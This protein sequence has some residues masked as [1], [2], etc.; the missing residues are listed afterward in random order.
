MGVARNELVKLAWPAGGLSERGASAAPAATLA[1]AGDIRRGAAT[2]RSAFAGEFCSRRRESSPSCRSLAR[3]LLRLCAARP[4][5]GP[6]SAATRSISLLRNKQS[7]AVVEMGSQC[8]EPEIL[9]QT[10]AEAKLRAGA[11]CLLVHLGPASERAGGPGE[12][13]QI[14]RP[15][16]RG[17]NA[18]RPPLERAKCDIRRWH[19]FD[20]L[21]ICVHFY[22]SAQFHSQ[23]AQAG[24]RLME[25]ARGPRWL[26]A[27]PARKL[28]SPGASGERLR[29]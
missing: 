26:L 23:A 10:G 25:L 13:A 16:A 8:R 22:W 3:S 9:G 12:N 7:R 14:G 24:G 1:S 15:A 17:P 20:E 5:A 4:P 28:F 29:R 18:T 2:A 19:F 6:A 21:P 11:N 27:A